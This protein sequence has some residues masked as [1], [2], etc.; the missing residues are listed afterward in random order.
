MKVTINTDERFSE[1]EI[2]IN[3]NRMNDDIEKLLSV[4]RMMDMKL[5]GKK[6][7]QQFIIDTSQILYIESI[8]KRTFIY[9]QNDVF[10]S[11]HRLYELKEKLSG[12][13]FLQASKNCIFNLVRLQS[14]K[15]DL[16]Q[17]LILTMEG[18]L[19]II[20]SR[21][22]SGAVKEKLREVCFSQNKR[23]L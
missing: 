23:S 5:I 8:D 6:D 11:N 17:R 13:D 9:T 12:M 10:E 3:C 4:I 22:Y 2:T 14:L 1:T 7:G 18:D 21:Q 15:S 20:V 16:E 19:K